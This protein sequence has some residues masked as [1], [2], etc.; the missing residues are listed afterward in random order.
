MNDNNF[1][2]IRINE[3]FVP[4][5]GPLK[6]RAFIGML[7]LP[8]TG[9]CIS[10]T[11]IGSMLSESIAW[12]RVL[13]IFIIYFLALG[14][15][16]HAADNLGS[17]KIKP[18]GNYFSTFEL[19]LMV[20]GGLSVSYMLGIY[21]IITFAPLLLF[22][23]IIE[24]FFLFAYNFELFNGLFHNNFWFA[25]S[26]GA[27]PLLAGFVIQTNSISVLSLISSIMAFLVA[28]TEIRISR[29]YKELKRNPQ[30]V[31]DC[32]AEK[33]ERSLKVISLLTISFAV[34]LTVCRFFIEHYNIL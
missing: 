7:F 13:S 10:F 27:L 12:D 22:I 32:N 1:K 25:V 14:V 2:S 8:Y 4:R 31:V 26:W 24:G 19:R 20:I 9:M 23:A 16:A 5:F 34:L 30:D 17:K 28:Y 11:I 33:L 18:W 6:F 29:K 21:Y 15:S 3:W